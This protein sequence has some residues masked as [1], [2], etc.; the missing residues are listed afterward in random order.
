M[1]LNRL[2]SKVDYGLLS[3]FYGALLTR[4]QSSMLQ[5]YCDEDLSLAEVAKQLGVTR[6]CVNDTINRA[7]L[8]LDE[9][10]NLLGLMDRFLQQRNIMRSCRDLINLGL[11]GIDTHDNL[12]S[13]AKKLD[14]YLREEDI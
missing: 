5:L 14:D 1:K 4:R 3:S 8:K 13:A 2:E 12:E 10:E 7:F 9:L 6:Q 11:Q